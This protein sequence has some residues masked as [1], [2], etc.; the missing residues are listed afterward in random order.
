MDGDSLAIVV[1]PTAAA[2]YLH[3]YGRDDV[4][5]FARTLSPRVQIVSDYLFGDA[6]VA[7][8]TGAS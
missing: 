2:D 5:A 8:Q 3:W 7:V 1:L 6:T 4:L